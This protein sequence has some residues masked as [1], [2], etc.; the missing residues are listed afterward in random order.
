METGTGVDRSAN[1]VSSGDDGPRLELDGGGDVMGPDID[2]VVAPPV[3]AGRHPGRGVAHIDAVH[4]PALAAVS[5][6]W[7]HDQPVGQL[8]NR[9]RVLVAQALMEQVDRRH[10]AVSSAQTVIACSTGAP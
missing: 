1:P 10:P 6:R 4:Q 5:L 2:H 7:N 8:P 3:E 9:H